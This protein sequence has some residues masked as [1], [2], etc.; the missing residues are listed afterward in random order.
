MCDYFF[1]IN[2]VYNSDKIKKYHSKYIKIS[3][4]NIS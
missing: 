2:I 1:V 4:K 3:D